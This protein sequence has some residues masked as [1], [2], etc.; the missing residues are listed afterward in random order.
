[1][2]TEGYDV[3]ANAGRPRTLDDLHAMFQNLLADR[4]KLRFHKETKDGP[5]Y[6]LTVDA[7]GLKMRAS[8]R[9]EQFNYPVSYGQGGIPSRS[10]RM[11][12]PSEVRTRT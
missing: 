10:E 8:E 4:F 9:A 6:A 12:R 7:A 1:M 2:A 3:D 5:V 11:S